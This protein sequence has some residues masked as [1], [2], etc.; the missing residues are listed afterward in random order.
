MS[1]SVVRDVRQ[2]V[3]TVACGCVYLCGPGRTAVRPYLA[4]CRVA[5][6]L[7]L[8]SGTHCSASF[9][10]G[11]TAVRPYP[12]LFV[13]DRVAFLAFASLKLLH[14]VNQHLHAFDG[15][16]VVHTSAVA[17]YGAVTGDAADARFFPEFVELCGHR[18]VVEAEGRVHP[19]A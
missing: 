16:R 9:C 10:G 13:E 19:R 6:S 8:L 7:S 14:H 11:R 2:C 5:L 18:V 1:I 4:S 12:G 3:L 17:A 15:Q